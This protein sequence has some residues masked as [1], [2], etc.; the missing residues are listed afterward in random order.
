M[1]VT[2]E[3][4]Q[5]YEYQYKVTAFIALLV[6]M[7]V[8][9][10]YVETEGSEDALLKIKCDQDTETIEVQVKREAHSLDI[11]KM[12]QWL[13]HFQERKADNNLLFRIENDSKSIAL[14]VT[15]SR[16]SDDT[17]NLRKATFSINPHAEI[18]FNKDFVSE[19][20]DALSVVNFKSDSKLSKD[21][22][23]FCKEQA[24][25][26]TRSFLSKLLNRVL[27]WEE[28]TDE[29]VDQYIHQELVST[30]QVS[31]SKA[32]NVYFKLLEIVRNGRDDGTDI[33]KPLVQIIKENK[34]GHP[35]IDKDYV[36]RDE[37]EGLF[38]SIIKNDVLLLTGFSQCGKTEI[39][40]KIAALLFY[41]GYEYHLTGEVNEVS[42]I[43]ST[44]REDKKI[45][46]LE[47]PLDSYLLFSC[48]FGKRIM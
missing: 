45:V 1:S 2:K 40:K 44:N 21:R 20:K 35:A 12:V 3:G 18:H 5:G 19:F 28:V 33:L 32:E 10:V 8:A 16:C 47:D 43:F 4:I 23:S 7:E 42:R 13:A 36:K 9:E 30:H 24:K 22:V 27:I 11:S 25:K 6:Y 34:I 39:A 38:D 31:E 29:K 48:C 26:I 14:F 41:E 15:R 17:V 46:V 37:E